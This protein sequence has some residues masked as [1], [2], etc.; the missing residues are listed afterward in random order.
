[1]KWECTNCGPIKAVQFEY[2]DGYLIMHEDGTLEN[3]PDI[4][5]SGEVPTRLKNLA[6]PS[7]TCGL[8]AIQLLEIE[9][10][11]K[12]KEAKPLTGFERRLIESN[13][14]LSQKIEN[15]EKKGETVSRETPRWLQDYDKSWENEK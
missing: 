7:C 15:M 13:H 12:I 4:P 8:P 1:M 2:E 11:K 10:P 5:I 6:D 3:H 9:R 14:K